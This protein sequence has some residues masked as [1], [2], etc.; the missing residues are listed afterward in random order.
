MQ[1]DKFKV[2]LYLKKSGTNFFCASFSG[3]TNRTL[4]DSSA[5]FVGDFS[6]GENRRPS[7]LLSLPFNES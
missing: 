2:L 3:F 4:W 1:R 6:A 5:S 7:F